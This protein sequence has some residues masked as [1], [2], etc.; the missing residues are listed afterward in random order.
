MS[1]TGNQLIADVQLT[2]TMPNNQ[3]LLTDD[4]IL[5]LAN[6]EMLAHVVPMLVSLNQ[7]F[8][9]TL[10]DTDV[11]VSGKE[12]YD[13]PYRAIGRL[14]RD[15]KIKDPTSGGNVWNCDQITLE[16]AHVLAYTSQRFSYYFKGD[17]IR[18]VP[19]P[20][21]A[22]TL[23]KYYLLRPGKITKTDAAGLVTGISGNIVNVSVMPESF[24]AGVPVDFIRGR[25]GNST[26][27]MDQTITNV[28]GLQVTVS[29][30]P[31]SLAVGDYVALAETSPVIQVPDEVF[32]YLVYLTAKR[33]L[34]AIGDY[35][36]MRSV[37]EQIPEKRRMVETLL[38]PRNQGETITIINRNGLLRGNRN[39]FWRGVVR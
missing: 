26:I 10:D 20:D 38:A 23:M 27:S 1:K 4:R 36:G 17:H 8:F 9:T 25:Q 15:L 35:D 3:V 21:S 30:V 2:I 11:T 16:D 7:E 31:T 18:L 22:Y 29:D 32:P 39:G 28:S 12:D 5:D 14:L 24:A 13:I 34:Y 33:C 37:E 6:E 19:T